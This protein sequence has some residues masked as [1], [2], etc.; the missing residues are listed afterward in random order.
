MKITDEEIDAMANL[1]IDEKDSELENIYKEFE[2]FKE[3]GELEEFK[4]K[5]NDENISSYEKGELLSRL[6]DRF[7]YKTTFKRSVLYIRNV[8]DNETKE[9]EEQVYNNCLKLISLYEQEK[10]QRERL[11]EQEE[12]A[13]R[14][15]EEF[16]NLEEP[17]DEERKQFIKNLEENSIPYG[18]FTDVKKE[19]FKDVEKEIT[20][21]AYV[22][23]DKKV[24]MA[25]LFRLDGLFTEKKLKEIK[26][27]L[28]D[29]E[30]EDDYLT[31][32]L[33]KKDYSAST[34]IRKR[35]HHIT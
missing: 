4:T 5:I 20:M 34:D 28:N 12:R 2:Q 13:N 16:K 11:K 29:C 3:S 1:I 19:V 17:T 21:L 24:R 6:K 30:I 31:E 14:E 35:C 25:Y 27:D 15:L 10:R 18:T 9:R 33:I 26:N 8:P 7:K 32:Y 22:I 23:T